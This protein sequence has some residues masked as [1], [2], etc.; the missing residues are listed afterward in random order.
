MYKKALVT[1]PFNRRKFANALIN[2]TTG[3]LVTGIGSGGFH[4][5]DEAK[6]RYYNFMRLGVPCVLFQVILSADKKK[7][8]KLHPV[9]A[10]W[11]N[12]L[13]GEFPG[14]AG[15]CEY[16]KMLQDPAFWERMRSKL[17]IH[18][19]ILNSA[20]SNYNDYCTFMK[21]QGRMK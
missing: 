3:F 12:A 1:Y 13:S 11:T 6:W 20:Q 5:L 17:A 8:I 7:S 14:D 10:N 21:Q 18:T 19:N 9:N 4:D 16:I 2:K 15:R